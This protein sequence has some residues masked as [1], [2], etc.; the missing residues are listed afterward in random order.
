MVPAGTSCDN[1]STIV[2]FDIPYGCKGV[3]LVLDSQAGGYSIRIGPG[4][5]A[6]TASDIRQ[7]GPTVIQADIVRDSPDEII[8]SIY[9]PNA[10]SGT[11]KVFQ[12]SGLVLGLTYS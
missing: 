12:T 5:S 1:V 6:A 4:A 3:A 11:I 10:L 2:P 8:V 9:N 7:I